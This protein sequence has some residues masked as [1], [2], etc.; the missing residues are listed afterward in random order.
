MTTPSWTKY[1]YA[2]ALVMAMLSTVITLDAASYYVAPRG[3]NSNPGSQQMPWLTITYAASKVNTGDTVRV[4]AGTYDER[5]SVMRG[6]N[7]GAWVSFVA[8]G[9][10]V[11]RGFDLVDVGYVRVLGFEITH[12]KFGT[13]PHTKG[14][15]FSRT[16][17]NILIEGCYIHDTESHGIWAAGG[18]TLSYVTFRGNRLDYIG[19]IPNVCSNSFVTGILGSYATSH[20]LLAEYNT[21]T[22][23][24][25]FISL[26]GTNIIVRNNSLTDFK[27][28]YWTNAA[29][30]QH[31]DMFQPGS[32]QVVTM[33]RNHLYEANF[34]GDST[35]LNSHFGI[36][37]DTMYAGDTNVLIRGNVGY[38]F[39]SSAIGVISAGHVASVNN[40]FYKVA[41]Y[42]GVEPLVWY[43]KSYQTNYPDKCICLNTLIDDIGGAPTAIAF[44]ISSAQSSW[45]ANNLGHTAGSHTSYV[46]TADPLFQD[47]ANKAFRLQSN[48]PAINAGT[49]VVWITSANGSG[50]SFDVND[51]LLLC[52]GWGMVEG[53]TVTIGSTTTRVAGIRNNTVSVVASVTWTQNQAV[54][55]GTD[56]TP[57]IGALPYGSSD[58]T[59]ATLTQ[60]GSTYTVNTTG[61]TRGVWFYVDG[62]PMVWDSTPPFSATF[63]NGTVTAQAYALYAQA[64]PVVAATAS[65]ST[66]VPP[67][68]GLRVASAN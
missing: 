48:S 29:D 7:S 20:H 49:N 12:A 59:R 57:D 13:A 18:S 55:L 68:D 22:R 17:S 61:S 10:A 33:M 30:A 66:S 67:P 39:G 21:I 51:G 25:D 47:A 43:K 16:C 54:Y 60:S 14:V 9:Q 52:D 50:T 37:Q 62:I 32:D 36:F 4:Q 46:S 19:R 2:C 8:D 40:T 27:E 56:T 11:V 44:S 26:F 23:S 28:S 45:A 58:L 24:G 64:I 38:L 41:Q 63:T 1:P 35:N 6:G 65:R 3:S 31:A 34:C 42:G 53:D 5:A 15:S